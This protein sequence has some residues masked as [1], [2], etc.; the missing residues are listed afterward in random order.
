MAKATRSRTATPEQKVAEELGNNVVET[1]ETV[2]TTE[3]VENVEELE[4]ANVKDAGATDG[5][6]IVTTFTGSS[7]TINVG[8]NTVMAKATEAA[9]VVEEVQ[10]KLVSCLGL[11]THTARIGGK[12]FEV[13]KDK[14]QQFPPNVSVILQRSGHLIVK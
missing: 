9:D 2:G 8:N 11:K 4:N 7:A 10:E 12:I 6:D 14:V 13:I 3:T 1:T 5:S